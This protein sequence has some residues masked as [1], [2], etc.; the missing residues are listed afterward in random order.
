M[1]RTI[2]PLLAAALLA[3]CSPPPKSPPPS[4]AWQR[5]DAAG[6][7]M[8]ADDP[9][10]HR[11]VFD[12]ATGLMWQVH[13]ETAGLHHQGNRYSWY[14]RDRQVNMGEPGQADGGLCSGSACDTESLVEAVNRERLCGHASWRMPTR[15]EL[16]SLGEAGKR[17]S[18]QIVDTAF[19]P[20]AIAGEYWSS[21]T[22]RLYPQS[23]WA[24]S[25]ANGLDRADV[26]SEPKAV[27]LV[28][29]HADN[30]HDD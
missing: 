21:E 20:A 28:R 12:S 3:A 4:Q 17:D 26:K 19:F 10:A 5:V 23:A 7:I 8:S 9:A 14:S 2:V 11:C 22:F 18:G 16:M 30:E 15:E 27:R 6:H 25:F 24:V 29:R 13:R 1:S